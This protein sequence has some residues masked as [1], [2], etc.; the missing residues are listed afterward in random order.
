MSSLP[1]WLCLFPRSRIKYLIRIFLRCLIL[2]L[3]YWP[4]S[5]P[6]ANIHARKFSR[7]YPNDR[8]VGPTSSSCQVSTIFFSLRSDCRNE[9][10]FYKIYIYYVNFSLIFP[11]CMHEASRS[12]LVREVC[13]AFKFQSSHPEFICCPVLPS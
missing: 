4:L 7:Y 8:F 6:F 11:C 1:H 2:H 12:V 10:V 9:K 13:P 5:R 3:T